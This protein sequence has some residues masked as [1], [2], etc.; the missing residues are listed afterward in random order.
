MP[1]ILL[2]GV[3]TLDI[4]NQLDSYPV[5]DSEV[6]AISQ[7]IRCGGNASNSAIVLQQ[8][9]L[10]PC[11]LANMADDAAA[12]QIQKQLRAHSVDTSMCPVQPAGTTPTSYINMSQSNGSRT[13]VHYRQLD[14][15]QADYFCSMNL[16]NFQWLHFEARNCIQL[17]DMLLHARRFNKKISIELEKPRDHIDDILAYADVL[18]ISRPFAESRNFT[19]ATECLEYF[20]QLYPD[21]LITCTWGDKGAWAHDTCGLLHQTAFKTDQLIETLGAGDTFNAG[22]I[23]SLL[24]R[25]P[26]K[27]A[28]QFACYLASLKCQ[29]A[30][31]DKLPV[32]RQ[33][34]PLN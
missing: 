19:S 10:K 8:L 20:H 18:M 28:L 16:E 30:G 3:A 9:G 1:D 7:Q 29:Q 2:T 4:I 34:W 17:R 26:L 21:T 27:Q 22:L 23:A 6:R 13:I 33:Y 15:L 14:E 31:F 25:H 24:R 32:S 5:E 11:L 12:S